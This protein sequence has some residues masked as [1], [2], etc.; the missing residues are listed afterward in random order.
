RLPEALRLEYGDPRLRVEI[1]TCSPKVL[2]FHGEEPLS[3]I[4]RLYARYLPSEVGRSHTRTAW[5][6][7]DVLRLSLDEEGYGRTLVEELMSA[8]A[9][10]PAGSVV[11]GDGFTARVLAADRRGIRSVEFHFDPLPPGAV[12]RIFACRSGHLAP[13][14]PPS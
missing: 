3:P 14:L 2:P 7:R 5:I 1:L 12:R 10:V 11:R 13:L 6:G 4:E 8:R 9:D